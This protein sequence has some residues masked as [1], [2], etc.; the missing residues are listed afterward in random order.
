MI[1]CHEYEKVWITNLKKILWPLNP[2]QI[3]FILFMCE[4]SRP[5]VCSRYCLTSSLHQKVKSGFLLSFFNNQIVSSLDL[6]QKHNKE[7]SVTLSNCSSNLF[8]LLC[9]ADSLKIVILL[10]ILTPAKSCKIFYLDSWLC[11][12]V[13]WT[14]G[15]NR[16]DFGGFEFF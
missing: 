13:I 9:M 3:F 12:L 1:N 8:Y 10:G 15:G 6:V 2:V 11:K 4:W 5:D 7:L 16:L 14:V